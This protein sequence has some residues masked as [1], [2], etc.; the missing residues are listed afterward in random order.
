MFTVTEAEPLA[1]VLI[2]DERQERDVD[3]GA[4]VQLYN[5][6][7]VAVNVNESPRQIAVSGVRLCDDGP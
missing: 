2:L 6:P 1:V 5:N 4:L 7:P 3:S